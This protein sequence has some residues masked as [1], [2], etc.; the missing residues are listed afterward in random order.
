M[1]D[2]AS[3]GHIYLPVE[4]THIIQV[5]S[6]ET[7]ASDERNPMTCRQQDVSP[8]WLR[9]KSNRVPSVVEEI[10]REQRPL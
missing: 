1:P 2:L 6:T 10:N 7:I 4:G 5:Q 3:C 8:H 9:I